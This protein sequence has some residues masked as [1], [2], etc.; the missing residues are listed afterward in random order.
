MASRMDRYREPEQRVRSRSASNQELYRTIY[1]NAEYTNIEKIVTT[2]NANE[3]NIESI[4]KLISELENE[5][6]T[7]QIVKRDVEE[8]KP[9]ELPPENERNYDIRDILIKA[10]TERPHEEKQYRSLK[11]NEYNFLNNI[12][13][14]DKKPTRQEQ[15][16]ELKELINTITNSTLLNKMSDNELSMDL[17]EDLKSNT[18]IG[19][20][21]SI[22]SIIDEELERE[23]EKELEKTKQNTYYDLDDNF[24]FDN[25]DFDNGGKTQKEKKGNH[26]LTIATSFFVTIAAIAL[27]VW[28]IIQVMNS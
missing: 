9:I 24:G 26:F 1:D 3:V 23:K 4:R 27:I 21:K 5:R 20:S 16:E 25:R 13:L 14:E 10:K 22:R 19:D 11:N 2:P 28:I 17:F 8:R 15:E 18:M 6:T 12:N 7:R